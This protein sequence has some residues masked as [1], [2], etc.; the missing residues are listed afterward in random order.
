MCAHSEEKGRKVH[1]TYLLTPVDLHL[2][3]PDWQSSS[4]RSPVYVT[5]VENEERA[6]EAA[7]DHFYDA[8]IPGGFLRIHPSPWANT[9]FV[10]AT[11]VDGELDKSITVIQ[12]E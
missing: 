2:D 10:V 1:K 9:T 7:A 4:H 3:S 12:A 6:R 5:G 11:L 8:E